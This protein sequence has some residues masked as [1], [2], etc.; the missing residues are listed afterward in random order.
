MDRRGVAKCATHTREIIEKYQSIREASIMNK[1]NEG[2]LGDVLKKRKPIAYG[3]YWK[4][5]PKQKRCKSCEEVKGIECFKQLNWSDK[6]TSTICRS[7][8][9]GGKNEL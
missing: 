4:F 8:E 3:Y 6:R 9:N 1:V 7:C 2:N 5:I